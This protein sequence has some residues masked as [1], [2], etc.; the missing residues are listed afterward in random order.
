[1]F[2]VAGDVSYGFGPGQRETEEKVAKPCAGC[3]SFCSGIC[4]LGWAPVPAFSVRAAQVRAQLNS[5]PSC[6]VCWKIVYYLFY[7]AAQSI[8]I[9]LIAVKTPSSS[10]NELSAGAKNV[11][12]ANGFP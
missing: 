5:A 9:C 4:F 10:Q 6:L 2:S 11:Y 8:F 3:L 12:N 1:V 7:Y